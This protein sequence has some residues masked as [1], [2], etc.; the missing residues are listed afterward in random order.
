MDAFRKVYLDGY[1]LIGFTVNYFRALSYLVEQFGIESDVVGFICLYN[2]GKIPLKS[3]SI[4]R[5]FGKLYYPEKQLEDTKH[6]L[7]TP[8]KIKFFNNPDSIAKSFLEKIWNAYGFEE[9]PHFEG[10]KYNPE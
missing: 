9:V 2:I 10:D 1:S 8:I 6:L 4:N 3:K 5:K 7:V